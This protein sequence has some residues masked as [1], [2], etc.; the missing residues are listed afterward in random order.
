[1]NKIRIGVDLMGNENSPQ[2]LIAALKE[3]TPSPH[4]ELILIGTDEFKHHSNPFPYITA[5]EVIEM[6]EPPL[7]ALRKKK[8]ASL[9]IGMRLLK[10][11]KIEALVSARNTGALVSSAKMILSTL[12]GILRP[13]LLTLIPTKKNPVAVLDVG[14]NTQV[15]AKHLVQFALIGTAYQQA[16]GIEKPIIGLLNIGS[17]AVKGTSEH[18]LA[19]HNLQTIEHPTFRFAGNI[20][21][22]SVFDGNVDVLVTD[23]FTGNVFLKTAEGIATMIL[24]RIHDHIPPNEFKKFQSLHYAEYPGALLAGVKGIVIKCHSYS[25]PRGFTNGVLGAIAL[26]QEN[27]IQALQDKLSNEIT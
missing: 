15:Q 6:D 9:C 22:T 24:D 3:L 17:E 25:T 27:F 10:E 16:R 19:Y 23:G 8:K 1:M 5:P 26:A 13:C 18:R 7:A 14:A 11:G 20:E 12:T 4:I 21:G 2:D